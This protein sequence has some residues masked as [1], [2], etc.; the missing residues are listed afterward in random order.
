MTSSPTPIRSASWGGCQRGV[1]WRKYFLLETFWGPR[2]PLFSSSWRS[3]RAA[4]C[5]CPFVRTCHGRGVFPKKEIRPNLSFCT[6]LFLLYSLFI[7]LRRCIRLRYPRRPHPFSVGPF[8]YFL[9]A[10][11]AGGWPTRPRPPSSL[12]LILSGTSLLRTQNLVRDERSRVAVDLDLPHFFFLGRVRGQAI[13]CFRL[14]F[15]VGLS[16]S[17]MFLLRPRCTRPCSHLEFWSGFGFFVWS[18][19]GSYPP[20]IFGLYPRPPATLRLISCHHQPGMPAH[21]LLECPPRS[22]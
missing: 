2:N 17:G 16:A 20:L 22:V 19:A 5:V 7:F 13:L 6:F 8:F 18:G 4:R 15:L 3:R 1:L 11:R 12:R 9:S 21:H 10:I 14:L